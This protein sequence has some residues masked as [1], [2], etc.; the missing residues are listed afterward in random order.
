MGH[1]FMGGVSPRKAQVQPSL[2]TQGRFPEQTGS[3]LSNLCQNHV[4]QINSS[5]T[6]GKNSLKCL[7]QDCPVVKHS[8]LIHLE[9]AD[10]LLGGRGQM[11]PPQNLRPGQKSLKTAMQEIGDGFRRGEKLGSRSV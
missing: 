6:P 2:E 11:L 4:K 3:H 9:A 7:L 1:V 5:C 10:V 8:Q